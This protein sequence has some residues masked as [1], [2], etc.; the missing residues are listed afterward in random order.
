MLCA[1]LAAGS[2]GYEEVDA[3]TFAEWGEQAGRAWPA[4]IWAALPYGHRLELL[5]CAT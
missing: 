2:L 4:A 1:P 5:C 3:Q